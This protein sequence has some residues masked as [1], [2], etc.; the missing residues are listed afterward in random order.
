[1]RSHGWGGDVPA[2]DEE[3]VDR[4]LGVVAATVDRAEPVRIADVARALGVTRQTVYRYFSNTDAMLTAMAMR[5]ADGFL[6]Q[7]ASLVRGQRDPVAAVVEA[8]A[9]SLETLRA[10][11]HV[12][13]L[14]V[15]RGQSAGTT[16]LTTDTARAFGR[17]MFRR[18]EVDWAAW[19]YDEDALDELAEFTLRILFSFL[20]EDDSAPHHGPDLRRFLRR[21]VGPAIA[22]PRMAAATSSVAVGATVRTP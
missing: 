10:D 16:S 6:D 8:M 21:W 4:I 1:M 7:M 2:S 9:F 13:I 3:A 17:S 18:F 11:D 5:S 22:Y 12:R 14:L 20:L 15:G 19:G